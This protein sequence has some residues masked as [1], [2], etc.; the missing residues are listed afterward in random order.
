MTNLDIS[1]SDSNEN[2]PFY[3]NDFDEQ[4]ANFICLRLVGHL[5]YKNI[6][7]ADFSHTEQQLNDQFDTISNDL[8]DHCYLIK[9]SN[10]MLSSSDRKNS[11]NKSSQNCSEI[12]KNFHK[13]EYDIENRSIKLN[14]LVCF[15]I[16]TMFG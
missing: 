10:L 1:K 11:T 15:Y 13:K 16:N 2:L 12:Y 14:L 6:I 4:N 3:L 8:L 5:I 9:S 7:S